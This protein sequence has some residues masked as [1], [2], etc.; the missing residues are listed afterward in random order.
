MLKTLRTRL[1]RLEAARSRGVI[2][3]VRLRPD[4][5]G[6]VTEIRNGRILRRWDATPERAARL[7]RVA[8]W[9]R[10]SYGMDADAA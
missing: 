5:G 6:V 8:V 7:E 4:G 9:I 3:I 10:R 1:E 2:E